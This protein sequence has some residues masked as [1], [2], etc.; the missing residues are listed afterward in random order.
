MSYQ[1]GIEYRRREGDFAVKV[2]LSD[3]GGRMDP[4][5]FIEWLQIVE[6]VF[7]YKNFLPDKN[8]KLVAIKLKKSASL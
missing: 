8:V 4:S 7:E 3:F 2:D 6:H 1:F 5:K